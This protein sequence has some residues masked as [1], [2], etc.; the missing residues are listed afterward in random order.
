MA[1]VARELSVT[2]GSYVV[3]GAQATRI[4]ESFYINEGEYEKGVIE[5]TFLLRSATLW[6]EAQF[7]TSVSDAETAFLNPNQAITVTQGSATLTSWSHSSNTG[8]NARPKITKPGGEADTGRSRRYRVRIEVDLPATPSSTE[9]RRVTRGSV[10]VAYSPARRRTVT[11]VVLYTALSANASRAQYEASIAAYTTTVLNAL[12]GTYKL[13]EEPTSSADDQ[14]KLIDATRV[15]EEI[16]FTK[17]GSGDADVRGE[18]LTISRSQVG[19]GDTPIAG[20]TVDRL[21]T[22]TVTYTAW[23]DATITTNLTAKWAALFPS[24]VSRI[25]TILSGGGLAILEATPR[26]DEVENRIDA[27]VVAQ[28]STHKGVVEYKETTTD[29]K[30]FGLQLVGAWDGQAFSKYVFQGAGT[31]QR[32]IVQTFLTFGIRPAFSPA[33]LAPPAGMKKVEVSD[34]ISISKIRRGFGP[35]TFNLIEITRTLTLEFYTD[36]AAGGA[37]STVADAL[38]GNAFIDGIIRGR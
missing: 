8:F 19:P 2:Y 28:G 13:L 33:S 27:T 14:D 7:S 4:L 37:G 34:E 32:R 25:R 18:E 31:W 20:K 1:V 15:F 6:T 36:P 35:H 9:G 26:Y 22:I 23:I 38:T 11:V 30:A 17:V 10:N 3:G 5:F 12:G 29:P 21:V 24:I 16:I